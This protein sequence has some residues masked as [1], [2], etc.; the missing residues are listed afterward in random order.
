V[1]KVIEKYIKIKDKYINVSLSKKK[2][3]SMYHTEK[4]IFTKE[5]T[6]ITCCQ[7]TCFMLFWKTV[8]SFISNSSYHH[9]FKIKIQDLGQ[10]LQIGWS[11]TVTITITAS[12]YDNKKSKS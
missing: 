3:I 7:I 12:Y 2:Y 8:V 1:F 11:K 4:Y 9:N 6:K 10:W 5:W